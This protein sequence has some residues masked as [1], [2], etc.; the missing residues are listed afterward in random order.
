[1]TPPARIVSKLRAKEER[2][3]LA[4]GD[5]LARSSDEFGWGSPAFSGVGEIGDIL[6]YLIHKNRWTYRRHSGKPRVSVC[7][8]HALSASVQGSPLQKWCLWDSF[9][10]GSQN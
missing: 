2:K 7:D 9:W 1:M 8:P 6:L 4:T 10:T 5:H 3:E